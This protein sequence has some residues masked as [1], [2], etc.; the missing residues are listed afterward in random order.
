MERK[1]GETFEF[2]GKT[3]KVVTFNGCGNCAFRYNDCPDL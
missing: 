1:I 2:E 3:Y